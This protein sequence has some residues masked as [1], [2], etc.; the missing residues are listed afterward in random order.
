MAPGSRA[1]R[2][3]A[4]EYPSDGMRIERDP[5]T[6]RLR[7]FRA[8][9]PAGEEYSYQK[10]FILEL[11]I[12][13]RCNLNCPHCYAGAG[14]EDF[15]GELT[16][17]E[18]EALLADGQQVGIRELSLTGGEV[19]MRPDFFQVVDAGLERDYA[20]RFVTN[21][22]LLDDARLVALCDRPIKLITVSL[23]G[24][25][26]DVHDRLRGPETHA[27]TVAAIDRLVAAGFCVSVITAF[28]RINL[29][30][31]D[32]LL[33]FCQARGIDWQVQLTSAKGRCPRSLTLSPAQYY[34]LGQKVAQAL[35]SEPGINLIPMDDLATFSHFP[36]LSLLSETWQRQC[37]GGLLNVF[38]RANGDVTPCSALCFEEC[39]VGNVRREPLSVIL[40]EE[41]CRHNLAWLS[42]ETLEGVCASCGFK[43]ECQGGCPEILLCMGQRRTENEYCYHRLEQAEILDE[44]LGDG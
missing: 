27:R 39:I 8:E 4:C 10:P 36:P 33:E 30:E 12:T 38:V 14:D 13:R 22:T 26:A 19:F 32:G 29:G 16:L 43:Q 42:A 11:E 41:R 1:P 20:V 21:A 15:P 25:R 31:F 37:T 6:G 35:V 9:D 40:R 34:A 17:E 2:A 23:D 28:S 5:A 18:I 7:Y 44:V 24:A 3:I